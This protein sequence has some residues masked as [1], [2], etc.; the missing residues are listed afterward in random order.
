[1]VDRIN[2]VNET[3]IAKAIGY[4]GF[5]T[6]ADAHINKVDNPKLRKRLAITESIL[7]T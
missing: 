5:E 6:I 4:K 2:L 1:M 3:Y 7:V